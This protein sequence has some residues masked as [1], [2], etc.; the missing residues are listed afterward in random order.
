MGRVIFITGTDTGVGKTVLTSLC[1]SALLQAGRSVIAIKPFCSGTRQ[2][3]EILDR[4]QGGR[5]SNEWL[6]PFF[7]ERPA[8]PSVGLRKEQR[9]VSI[10]RVS[11]HIDALSRR[12]D[13]LLVEG[14]G[15]LLSPLGDG[16]SLAD[17]ILAKDC[18]VLLIARNR[19]GAINQSRLA[20][21]AL[22]RRIWPET[23]LVLMGFPG[24]DEASLSNKR[25][26]A[27][28]VMP[29][30]V[31]SLPYLGLGVSRSASKLSSLAKKNKK[32]LAR[33]MGAANLL[34]AL[35]TE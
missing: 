5:I 11:R 23:T 1:L 2:D 33:V 6:N 9:I 8:S 13:W 19:L 25:T 4:L 10:D 28:L 16:Y 15:G 14:A 29:A 12:C 22:P 21:N 32:T 31:V 20:I 17:L 3:A 27:E 35:A 24:K 18:R 26:L 34:L 30:A 7:I